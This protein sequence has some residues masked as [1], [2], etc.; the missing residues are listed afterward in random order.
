M[1]ANR[2]TSIRRSAFSRLVS[3]VL[4]VVMLMAMVPEVVL[5]TFAVS[6][7]GNFILSLSWNKNDDPINFTYDSTLDENKMVRLKVSY[8]NKDVSRTFDREDI[9]ITLKGIRDAV[10]SGESYI[11]TGIAANLEEDSP[12][13]YDWVY[14]YTAATDT[15]TFTNNKVIEDKSTFEG[16]FEIIWELPSRDTKDG[17]TDMEFKA[18]LHTAETNVESNSIYYNQIRKADEYELLQETTKL[19]KDKLPVENYEEYT[20]VSYDIGA[21]YKYFSKDVNG[22]ERFDCYFLEDAI[23][24][25]NNLIEADETDPDRILEIDGKRYKKYYAYKDIRPNSDKFYLRKVLVAYPVDKFDKTSLVTNYVKLYGTYYESKPSDYR[26]DEEYLLATMSKTVP[27]AD[28]DFGDIP[29]DIYDIWKHSYGVHGDYINGH[30]DE[31]RRRGAINS[32]N[33]SDGK[34]EYY[35]TLGLLLNFYNQSITHPDSY[36]L[37][38]VDDIIDVQ[39]KNGTIRRLEDDEYHFTKI[40][41]PSNSEITNNNNYPIT[42]VSSLSEDNSVYSA[43]SGTYDVEIYVRKIGADPDDFVLLESEQTKDLKITSSGQ[44]IYLPEDTVG[45]KIRVIDVKEGFNTSAFRCYY[46]FHTDDKDIDTEGGTMFNNMFFNLWASYWDDEGN[47]YDNIPINDYDQLDD[48]VKESWVASWYGADYLNNREYQ[49][50]IALYGK[51]V[52]REVGK[53][54]ILDI[55]NEFKLVEVDLDKDTSVNSI[56]LWNNAYHFKSSITSEFA[57]GEGTELSKFSIFTIIPKG[58]RLD[59]SFRDPESLKDALVFTTSGGYSSAEIASHTKITIVDDPNE[60]DGRQY[61]RF[62]FDFSDKPITTKKLTISGIPTYVYRHNLD[63]GKIIYTMR[64]AMTVDQPGKWYSNS[65]DNNNM[66]DFLWIDINGDNNTSEPASFASDT[67]SFANSE[68]FEMQLT[69]FVSTPFSG[70]IMKTDEDADIF[71]VPKTYAG[72]DYSYFLSARVNTGKAKNIVFVDVIEPESSSEWQG[73]FIG[74]DY[75]QIVKQLDYT[76]VNDKTPTIYYSS[77]VEKFTKE[78]DGKTVID[79]EAFKKGNWTTVRP[80][81]VRSIAVDFGEGVATTGMEMMLEI[82][83]KAPKDGNDYNKRATNSCSVGYNWIEKA[84]TTKTYPDYLTSNVVPVRYVPK[85]KIILTKKDATSGKTI[86]GAEFELYKKGEDGGNDELIGTYETNQNGRITVSDLNYGTYYFKET[87]APTGYEISGTPTADIRL[88]EEIDTQYIDFDNERLRGSVTVKKVSDRLPDLTLP[89]AKFKLY[90]SDGVPV[91]DDEYVTGAD[92]ILTITDLEWGKY[93]VMESEPPVGYKLSAEKYEFEINAE[94]VA[95]PQTITAVNEQLPATAILEKYEL[96]GNKYS[97][98][99]NTADMIF[100][101]GAPVSGAVYKLYDENGKL[102]NTKITDKD[103]RIYA[104]DLT[105]G[106]YYFEEYTAAIG[107]EKYPERIEF[108]VG[109]EHTSAD[110]VI[111]TADVRKIG[112]VWL[113]K[114]DDEN[115]VVKGAGYG[116]YDSDGN[117][118]C[119]QEVNAGSNDGKYKY[120]HGGTVYADMITSPEG[121]VEI[122]GLYWGDYYLQE[123]KAP[124]GYELSEEQYPFTIKADNVSNTVMKYATDDRIKGIVELTKVDENDEDRKLKGAEFNLYRNDGSLYRENLTTDENGK[125]RVEGIEWGS[126][127]FKEVKAPPGYG[128]NPQNIKFSVNYMTAG[129][130]QEITVAD[131]QKNYKL[132]VAKKIYQKDV[133][134]AHGNPTF[135]FEVVNDATDEKYYKIVSFSNNNVNPEAEGYAEVSAV[136]ALPMGTYT[137]SEVS[138]NRYSLSEVAVDGNKI[139]GQK[140]NVTLDD[141]NPEAGVAVT[142]TNN[143]TDQSGTSHNSTVVNMFSRAHKLTSIVVDYQGPQILTS[144]TIPTDKLT[145]YAVYDDGT[146]ATV[147]GYVLDPEK[148]GYE[149]NGS[150]DITVTYTE[151]GITRKDTFNVTVDMPSPFTARFVQKNAYGTYNQ[152]N[153]PEKVTIDGTEYRGM[154]V[155]TGYFGTSSVINFPATLTGYIPTDSTT[156]DIRYAGEKF[157]VVGVEPINT[158]STHINVPDINNITTVTFADGIEFIGQNALRGF[159]KLTSVEFSD[160]ITAIND[161]AFYNCTGLT[162]LN[163]PAS[164]TRIGERAFRDCKG[165]TKLNLPDNLT[166]IGAHAFN[167]CFRITGLTIPASVTEIGDSAFRQCSGLSGPLI[168]AEGSKLKT[169]GNQAF[170]SNNGNKLSG[171]LILPDSLETIGN[172]AFRRCY[173]LTGDLNIPK[174]V[175]TIGN[176]AFRECTGM[177][178]SLTIPASVES[179]GSEAFRECK[180]KGTLTF[181]NGS[182]LTEIKDNVFWKVPFSGDLTIPEGVTSIGKEA[183]RSH[184]SVISFSG[185]KLTLPST[186]QSIGDY[187]FY[188]SELTGDLVIPAGVRSIGVEA[189]RECNFNGTLTFESGSQ[190]TEIKN[191]TFFGIPFSGDLNIPNGVTAIGEQAFQSYDITSFSGGTLTLPDTLKSIGNQAFYRCDFTGDLKI[192]NNV[193]TIGNGAFKECKFTG[194]LTLSENLETIGEEAFASA[195]DSYSKFTGQLIIPDKVTSIGRLAFDNCKFFTGDVTLPRSLTYIGEEVF[196]WCGYNSNMTKI[197]VPN[198][199]KDQAATNGAFKN[200]NAP[201][202]YYD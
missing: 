54:H 183:F 145:V 194:G 11:P 95:A 187:A 82:K 161:Y 41:I 109:P 162:E 168:F 50:D 137:V 39:L 14:S 116:L 55:P 190:L 111:K 22:A 78:E 129:K 40:Y 34:G 97:M 159:T 71:T 2:M 170:Y 127:Y 28:Y 61:V 126:Y 90:Y 134:F 122:E 186:L 19:N 171:N 96:D 189:F 4:A 174:N 98:P 119:V 92:G 79:R 182:K 184:D 165:L 65:S 196:R 169:I 153:I 23:V 167:N 181:E 64:A 120:V 21:A 63:Y 135:T 72:G 139:D 154:V 202:E 103:G 86:T 173:D 146:Q 52:D 76:N 197:I 3:C 58:L 110:L 80:A 27:L 15:Y 132:T 42:A 67:Y 43:A 7:T 200:C 131:P 180:F 68:N 150:F 49:R 48:S 33:L 9:T 105:F 16:S 104:E 172:E 175:K 25:S 148:L 198:T 157:K 69:K 102:V 81:T 143:K 24:K 121:I 84:D 45:F 35:S 106:T 124:K 191:H 185:G 123:T 158:S 144:E 128:L 166:S 26:Y 31:C 38:F 89:G 163:L 75:S 18:Q 101:T 46:V 199:I 140:A 70:G 36:D 77:E 85:G 1:Q 83:M 73:E 37:E 8:S 114:R 178:G 138:A 17:I 113:E 51:P 156:E 142:F 62:D 29:G 6:E 12:K 44:T 151:D 60:Y 112:S 57:L 195:S 5:N 59:E 179:I 53:S 66:E 118:L 160:T 130:V 141:S 176:G 155:I 56:G 30:C 147:T 20:W 149:N 152:T 32:I 88:S 100:D 125:L 87:D 93:Y 136:F 107:Y 91:S 193:T 201:I 164:L 108:T 99:D 177:T 133:V 13:T 10:R 74:V 188:Q 94:N 47:H 192:P 117:R 115:D